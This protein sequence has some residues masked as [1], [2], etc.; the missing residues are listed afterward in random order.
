MQQG[1]CQ[2]AEQE[3]R[4]DRSGVVEENGR[5]YSPEAGDK[6]AAEIVFICQKI[7]HLRPQAGTGPDE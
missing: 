4:G 3:K 2:N 5:E 1:Q 6:P 7:Y